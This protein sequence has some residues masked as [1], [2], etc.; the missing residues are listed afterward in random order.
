L[1]A[2]PL[3]N[4]KTV[5][6]SEAYFSGVEGPAFVL[7]RPRTQSPLCIFTSTSAP[8]LPGETVLVCGA[9]QWSMWLIRC[10]HPMVQFGAQLLAVK[11]SRFTS[12][13]V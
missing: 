12:A 2:R 5:I 4:N 6:L 8:W 1:Q 13:V 9:R 3:L 7:S 10:T 11:N